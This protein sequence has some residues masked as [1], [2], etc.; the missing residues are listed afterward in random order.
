MNTKEQ[1]P[2]PQ[3]PDTPSCSVP[4]AGAALGL[5]RNASYEAAT[6]GE[7]KTL[8]FGKGERKRKRVPTAWLRKVLEVE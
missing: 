1:K 7:I 5:G 2:K 8:E 6:R 4:V 3:I